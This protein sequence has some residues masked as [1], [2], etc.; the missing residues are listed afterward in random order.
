[1]TTTTTPSRAP[2]IHAHGA[3]WGGYR[4]HTYGN[5]TVTEAIFASPYRDAFLAALAK[6]TA[7]ANSHETVDVF[8]WTA[9]YVYVSVTDDRHDYPVSGRAL[10]S[11]DL[12]NGKFY[13]WDSERRY[14]FARRGWQ[15]FMDRLTPIGVPIYG[16]ACLPR[17]KC[18]GGT[19]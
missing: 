12:T 2:D 19:S 1:M 16:E 10:V 14:G 9:P 18:Q 5:N 3:T 11:F 8:W 13:H 6:F 17:C 7:K 4:D 15:A